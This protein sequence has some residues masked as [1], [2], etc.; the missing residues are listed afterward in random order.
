MEFFYFLSNQCNN[1]LE[2]L[3]KALVFQ[4]YQTKFKP[5]YLYKK[6][7][8][9][10]SKLY[11]FY[12]SNQPNDYLIKQFSKNRLSHDSLG[13]SSISVSSQKIK[14]NDYKN[15]GHKKFITQEKEFYNCQAIPLRSKFRA[16]LSRRKFTPSSLLGRNNYSQHK[17][18]A[19]ILPRAAYNKSTHSPKQQL[20]LKNNLSIKDIYQSNQGLELF[21][22]SL[23]LLCFSILLVGYL[24]CCQTFTRESHKTFQQFQNEWSKH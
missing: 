14:R 8:S 22:T 16:Y 18:N 4:R 24:N 1:D 11:S 3:S 2:Y 20:K 12:R 10:I 21:E 7:N 23:W 6:N 17:L 19:F 5:I 15:P 9:R 13:R